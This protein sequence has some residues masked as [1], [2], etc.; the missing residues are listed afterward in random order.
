MSWFAYGKHTKKHIGLWLR[1][2]SNEDIVKMVEK[3]KNKRFLDTVD[4]VVVSEY[5][6]NTNEVWLEVW[7]KNIIDSIRRKHRYNVFYIKTKPNENWVC[8]GD[9]GKGLKFKF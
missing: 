4:R 1:Y 7:C 3:T 5:D 9:L 8:E 2:H 6:K